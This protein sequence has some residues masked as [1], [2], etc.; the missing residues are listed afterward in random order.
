MSELINGVSQFTMKDL[1]IIHRI[2]DIALE[3]LIPT[4]L[5]VETRDS[6]RESIRKLNN[7]KLRFG[8]T[9]LA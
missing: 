1:V 6:I 8:K 5:Q 7:P 4:F 9:E 3:I 2:F